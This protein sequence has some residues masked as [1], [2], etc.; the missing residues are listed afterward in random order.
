VPGAIAQLQTHQLVG[1]RLDV[2]PAVDRNVFAAF[3]FAR[4]PDE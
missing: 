2:V 3:G 1:G 4:D